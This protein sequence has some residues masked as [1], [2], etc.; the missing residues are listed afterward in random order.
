MLVRKMIRKIIGTKNGGTNDDKKDNRD[1][2][3]G[4][5]DDKK[6]WVARVCAEPVWAAGMNAASSHHLFIIIIIDSHGHGS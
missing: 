1:K 2:N 4:K 6:D 5:N 3:A